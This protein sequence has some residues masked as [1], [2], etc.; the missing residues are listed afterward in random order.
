MPKQST[1][2]PLGKTDKQRVEEEVLELLGKDLDFTQ[3]LNKFVTEYESRARCDLD[4]GGVISGMCAQL[5]REFPECFE[6]VNAP[7]KR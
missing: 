6:P 3:R 2:P 1:K 7:R 4:A 5:R